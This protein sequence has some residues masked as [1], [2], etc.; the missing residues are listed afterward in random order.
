M[1]CMA[2]PA[3]RIRAAA[4]RGRRRA[5]GVLAGWRGQLALF[6][7]AYALYG[8]GRWVA[9]GTELVAV[10]NARWILELERDAGL[11]LATWLLSL[12][13]YALFPVAPPRLAGVGLVDTI[14][15]QTGLA[16]DSRLATALYNPL[17]AV[18]SLHAGFAFAVGAALLLVVRR[19]AA[20]VFWAAWP[21]LV[22]LAVVAT[23]NHFVFDIAAGLLLTTVGLLVA[24]ARATGPGP[25]PA[26]RTAPATGPAHAGAA[27]PRWPVA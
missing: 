22:G 23:G 7:A 18:P 14:T 13:V 10:A 21:A 1:S 12:P 20:R 6:A 11:A 17:A 2:H 3:P 24:R 4:H 25:A 5:P 26:W 15:T 19:P 27:R 9:T 8:L 16:L